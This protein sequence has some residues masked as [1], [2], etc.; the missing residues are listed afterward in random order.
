LGLAGDTLKPKTIGLPR[1]SQ[2][3]KGKRGSKS[4][5]LSQETVEHG[6]C[7]VF[8]TVAVATKHRHWLKQT[9]DVGP[10]AEPLTRMLNTLPIEVIDRLERYADPL[11]LCY[12]L[13]QVCGKDIMIELELRK[14][15]K[16]RGTQSVATETS[17]PIATTDRGTIDPLL[18]PAAITADPNL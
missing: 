13:Y 16:E 1:P 3:P 15:E 18:S 5:A 2:A 6:L 4:L 10:I 7:A 8:G 11:L 12:G 14:L 17:P 9:K